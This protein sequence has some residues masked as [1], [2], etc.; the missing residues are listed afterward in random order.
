MLLE[1]LLRD[2]VNAAVVIEDDAT[3]AGGA[4]VQSEDE[5]HNEHSLIFC[6]EKRTATKLSI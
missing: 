5:F 1:L 2:G 4:L 6:N 3:A